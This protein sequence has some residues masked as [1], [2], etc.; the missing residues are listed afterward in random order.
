[1]HRFKVHVAAD[2]DAALVES[3]NVTPSDVNDRRAG[4][5]VLPN[6]PGNVYANSAYW[7]TTFASA[8]QTK[9]RYPRVVQTGVWGR[10]GGSALRKL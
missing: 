6:D 4:G 2:A 9:G 7:G 1:M 10:P 5:E 8:A 3:L